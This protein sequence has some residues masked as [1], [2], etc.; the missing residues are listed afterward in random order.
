MY[1]NIYV[2]YYIIYVYMYDTINQYVVGSCVCIV[3]WYV[4]EYVV[5]HYILQHHILNDIP[6]HNTYTTSLQYH[7]CIPFEYE[8]G[9]G[10][11]P[12]VGS[13]QLQVS[14][15][16]EPYKRDYILQKRPIILRSLLH[17]ATPQLCMCY[18][19]VYH[20]SLL[21]KSPIKETIFCKRDLY[22]KE[23]TTC[24]PPIVVYVLCFDISQV[25]FAKEPYKRDC[26]LQK[27]P[28][29]LRSLQIVATPY[30]KYPPCHIPASYEYVIWGGYDQQAL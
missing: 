2:I 21:Q 25:S 1:M 3:Y 15:A 24:S 13:L 5:T 9:M 28:I 17:V 10:W 30:Q 26:I 20:R 12:L 19:L 4:V 8:G 16:E 29:I 7:T 18:V 6:I 22:F 23:P 27:R 14:F 11:L